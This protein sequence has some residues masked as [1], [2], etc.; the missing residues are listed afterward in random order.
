[1][2]PSDTDNIGAEWRMSILDVLCFMYYM[3]CIKCIEVHVLHV[4]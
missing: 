4:L 2:Q 1:M 3:C